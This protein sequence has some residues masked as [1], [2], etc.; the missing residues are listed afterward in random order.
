MRVTTLGLFALLLSLIALLTVHQEVTRVQA[1]YRMGR[2][3]LA[4]QRLRTRTVEL[5]A[6]VAQLLAPSRLIRLNQSLQLKLEPL[7]PAGQPAPQG[8]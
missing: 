8:R 6:E 1:A 2:L 4:R 3:V 7:T 5:D